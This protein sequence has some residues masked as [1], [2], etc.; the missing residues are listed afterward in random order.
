ML[1]LKKMLLPVDFS[2]RCEGAARYAQLIASRFHSHIIMLHVEHD[3]FLVGSEG[4]KGPPMGSIEHTLWLKTRLE[5][6]LNCDLRGSD[7]TR[8]LLEGDPARKIV[9]LARAEEAG[10]IVMPTHGHGPFGGFFWVPLW[11][12]CCMTPIAQSGLVFI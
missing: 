1:S 11:Q 3:P 2:D 12:R 5:S 7:V 4:M 10:L 6:C 8:V 9:E